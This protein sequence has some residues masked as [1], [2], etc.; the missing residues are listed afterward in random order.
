MKFTK[1]FVLAP[2]ER[3][4]EMQRKVLEQKLPPG[5]QFICNDIQTQH[6]SGDVS[7]NPLSSSLSSSLTC[8]NDSTQSYPVE[9][10]DPAMD[11]LST[12]DNNK[13]D[14][15]YIVDTLGKPYRHK[16]RELLE[17]I[18][19]SNPDV[20]TWTSSGEI[21]YNGQLIKGSNIIHLIRSVMYRT[22][23][24]KPVGH[25]EFKHYLRQINVP[26]TLVG[27]LES[28]DSK[29]KTKYKGVNIGSVLKNK[30]KV[31]G[32]HVRSKNIMWISL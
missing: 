26:L 30:R 20:F 9:N 18:Q 2:H 8:S 6:G 13:L 1:K 23:I 19:R 31:K 14:I 27:N 29:R 7:D 21:V 4:E 25:L 10:K 32:N 11:T 24:A 16:A 28:V 5:K 15:V 17:L 22:K 12:L 3:Y